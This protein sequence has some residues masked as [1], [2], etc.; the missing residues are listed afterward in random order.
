MSCCERLGDM[1]W[2]V[3]SASVCTRVFVC[4]A[5]VYRIFSWPLSPFPSST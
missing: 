5:P 1:G 2:N 3:T 4:A